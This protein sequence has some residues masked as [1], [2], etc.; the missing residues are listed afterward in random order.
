VACGKLGGRLA[1]FVDA[2]SI[3]A[4][5]GGLQ[6]WVTISELWLGKYSKSKY[7]IILVMLF[8]LYLKANKQTKRM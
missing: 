6:P 1:S 3:D 4:L 7:F 8:I 5:K 2:T